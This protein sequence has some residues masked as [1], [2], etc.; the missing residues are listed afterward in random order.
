[1]ACEESRQATGK[2]L[3]QH[4]FGILPKIRDVDIALRETPDLLKSVREVHPEVCF[5]HWNTQRPL[6]H[7][8]KS[9]FGFLERLA[10]VQ[11]VFGSSPEDV[12]T[13]VRRSHV[14]DDDILDAFAA[15]WTAQRIYD[16]SAV[17]VCEVDEHDEYDLPMQMWA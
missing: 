11:R 2:K 16:G 10:M 3:S 5:V 9:G 12:R 8:K 14:S 15:L 6:Q 17:K 1:M 4:T 7:P 13:I